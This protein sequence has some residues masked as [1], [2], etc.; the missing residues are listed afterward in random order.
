[1]NITEDQLRDMQARM[2][3]NFADA[4]KVLRSVAESL[5]SAPKVPKLRLPR[6]GYRSKTEERYG[7]HLNLIQ[8]AG[9]I[10]RWKYE[11]VSLVLAPGVRYLPDFLT[12]TAD[13]VTFWEVKGRKNESYWTRPLSKVKIR[14]AAELFPWW[15]FRVAWPKSAGAWDSFR[16]GREA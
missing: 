14:M 5:A 7:Q 11:P 4:G 13:I 8:M 15:E 16:I 3:G 2:L 9:Q 1:M 6:T 12:V 10:D